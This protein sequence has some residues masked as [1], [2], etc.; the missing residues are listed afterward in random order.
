MQIIGCLITWVFVAIFWWGAK[1]SVV[2]EEDFSRYPVAEGKVIGTY[3][4]IGGKRWMVK[5]SEPDGKKVI[6]AD[7][8]RSESTFH[9]ERYT[10]PKRGNTVKF[11]YW[12]HDRKRSGING[13]PIMY[14]IHFC[15]E[16]FYTLIKECARRRRKYFLIASAVMFLM[17][18]VILI[19]GEP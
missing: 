12:E 13:V 9:P 4:H 15:N 1:A 8:I 11:Y 19:W 14:Y 16:D 3:N 5:F 17:G 7:H 6:G 2:K 10:L 18:V